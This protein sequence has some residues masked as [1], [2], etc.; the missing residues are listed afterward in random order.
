MGYLASLYHENDPK[1]D[2]EHFKLFG[3]LYSEESTKEELNAALERLSA[4]KVL[5]HASF[6]RPRMFDLSM[7]LSMELEDEEKMVYVTCY[8]ENNLSTFM[9]M[10]GHKF[11]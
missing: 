7:D 10:N 6:R 3:I 2:N 5:Q 9:E 11:V 8:R 4:F 1:K